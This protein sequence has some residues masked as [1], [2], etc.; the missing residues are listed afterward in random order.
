MNNERRPQNRKGERNPFCVFY[1]I[2]LDHAVKSGWA[3]WDCSDCE[4]RSTR[5]A[6]MDVLHPLGGDSSEVY[7]LPSGMDDTT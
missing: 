3:F 7:D 1:S 5:D 2:C 6:K 4:N